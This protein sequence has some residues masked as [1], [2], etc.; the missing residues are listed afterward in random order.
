MVENAKVLQA[1]IKV[2]NGVVHL[3][4]KVLLVTDHV[5]GESQPQSIG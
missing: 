1:D 2:T 5:S 3:I 4:D